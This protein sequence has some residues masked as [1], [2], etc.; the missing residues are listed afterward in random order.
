MPGMIPFYTFGTH[1]FFQYIKSTNVNTKKHAAKSTAKALEGYEQQFKSICFYLF[2]STICM[3]FL[4]LSV[5]FPL[6]TGT[7]WAILREL[8]PTVPPSVFVLSRVPPC[9][10]NDVV[11]P[12]MSRGKILQLLRR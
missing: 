1:L 6:R 4:M 5:P 7:S 10:K 12:R 2:I 3:Q 11:H 8:K 9:D